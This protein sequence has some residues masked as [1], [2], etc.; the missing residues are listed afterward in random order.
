MITLVTGDRCRN[1]PS[2]PDKLE[3]YELQSDGRTFKQIFLPCKYRYLAKCPI[4]PKHVKKLPRPG[5]KLKKITSNLTC[6]GCL[7]RKE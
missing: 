4:C 1:L 7:E 5:C 6:V 2:D 3:G